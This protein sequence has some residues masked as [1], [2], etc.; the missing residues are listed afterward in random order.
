M[1][2]VGLALLD[3]NDPSKVIARCPHPVMEPETYYE[4]FGSFIPNVIFP[5]AAPV[6]NGKVFM[7]YGCCDTSIS[8]A[9]ARLDD[10]VNRVLR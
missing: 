7:Y 5:T 3:L 6:V 2:R 8:L 10:L 1:Y 4:R 9:T